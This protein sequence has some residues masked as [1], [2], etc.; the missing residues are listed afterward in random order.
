MVSEAPEFVG[1]LPAGERGG[2]RLGIGCG[3]KGLG[4]TT[5]QIS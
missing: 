5:R 4:E 3:K 1:D 2:V